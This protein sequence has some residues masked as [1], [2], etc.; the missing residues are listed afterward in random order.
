MLHQAEQNLADSFRW[1]P[2]PTATT[3]SSLRSACPLDVQSPVADHLSVTAVRLD[4]VIIAVS[5]WTRS[6][7]FYRTVIGAEVIERGADRVCFRVGESQLNVHGPGFVPTTNVARFPV[8]PGNSDI[9]FRWDG[10]IKDPP[11]HTSSITE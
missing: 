7:E 4:H 3:P 6:T 11:S 8:R 10:P 5:D 9:C 2:R 1:R